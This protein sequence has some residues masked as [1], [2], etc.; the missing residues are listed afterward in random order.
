MLGRYLRFRARRKPYLASA[1]LDFWRCHEFSWFFRWFENGTPG[2]VLDVG[3]GG[4][5][6]GPFL[7]K[8]WGC[9]SLLLDLD[10][11][12]VRRF[13]GSWSTLQNASHVGLEDACVDLSVVTS[14]LHILPDDGDSLAMSEV[15]RVLV[16]G[17]LCFLSTTWSRRYEETVP[18]TNPWG[19]IERWYDRAALDERVIGP[20]GMTPV[21]TEF[22]GDSQ[23]RKVA[24]RWYGSMFYRWR[25]ARRLFGWRQVRL[26][27]AT[28]RRDRHDA[29]DAC[30]VCLLL[31]KPPGTTLPPGVV[32]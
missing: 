15:G 21:R 27:A 16:P 17:G 12:L 22:F 30:N 13:G 7:E 28:E 3:G 14:L 26:A 24:E 4:S 11:S 5:L 19:L 32:E 10:P 23:T 20:S 2:V 9:R 29:S 25:W 8:V 18:E 1:G 31:Q 6:L